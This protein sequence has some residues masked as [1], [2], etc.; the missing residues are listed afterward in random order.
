M[1]IVKDPAALWKAT[2]ELL[3]IIV[4]AAVS[5]ALAGAAVVVGFITDPLTFAVVSAVLTSLGKA[6]DKYVHE[7]EATKATGIVPF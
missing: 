5:A 4:I 2:K 1:A 3:R 7:S 6:W